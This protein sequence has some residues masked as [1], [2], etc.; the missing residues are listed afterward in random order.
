MLPIAI[1]LIWWS[2]V[3][4]ALDNGLARTPP[5]GW[6][7]WTKFYCE[8]DCR[9]HPFACISEKLYMDM[10]DRLVEDG[11]VQAGYNTVHIDDCWMERERDSTG[12]LVAD[13]QRFPSG[14]A[15]LSDYMHKRGLK[16]G[17]YEDYGTKTCAGFPGSYGHLKMDAQ[18]FAEWKTDYLKLDGCNVDIRLMPQG[19]PEMGRELNLTGRPMIYSCSW[20]A[21]MI[22]HPEMVDYNVI[23]QYCNLWRNFDDISRSWSSILSIINYYDHHQ[24]KHIPAQGPGKWHDPDMIIVGNTEITPDQSKVQM[25]IWS[26]WSAPLIMSNDLRLIAPVYRDIL[27]N[28]RVI[29]VDQDPLGIMGRLVA[30]TTGIGVYVKPMTP[31]DYENQRY[32][33]AVAIL[34]RNLVNQMDVNFALSKIGLTNPGGYLIEDLWTGQPKGLMKPSDVYSVKVNPTGVDFFKATLPNLR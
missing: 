27:L 23:G 24:D 15:A 30:N 12:R 5:M 6:M 34:N 19:Y 9:R 22:D 32:S 7:S 31:V 29:A 10:A 20:P 25:S 1:G 17:I 3:T 14:I 16:L 18:T 8:M 33:Y 4:T 13:R 28:R 11:Y 26:I 21:Y 2:T